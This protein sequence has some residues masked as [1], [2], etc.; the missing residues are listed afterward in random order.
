MNIFYLS[1][2]ATECARLHVDCHVVKMILETAQLLSTAHRVLDGVEYID[3]SS[4]RN[5]KR[6]RLNNSY[7]DHLY[8]VSHVNHPSAIW[9]RKSY[10]NYIWLHSLLV[11]L[12]K[13]YSYRYGKIH[14]VEFSGLMKKLEY[15]PFNIRPGIFT[16]PTPAMPP[17]FI[18]E[19]DS[20]QSYRNYYRGS[21]QHLHSWKNR[22][23]PDFIFEKSLT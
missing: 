11:E 9:V 12:C 18:V 6:W 14:K 5:I 8:K 19:N 16:E 23:I 2:N 4:G 22:E 1:N 13:E 20:I 21:K 17:E 3:N 15:A 10:D 7:E